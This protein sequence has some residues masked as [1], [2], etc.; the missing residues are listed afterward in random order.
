MQIRVVN[1]LCPNV[2]LSMIVA[3][4]IALLFSYLSMIILMFSSVILIYGY[5]AKHYFITKFIIFSYN[6]LSFH[7]LNDVF[8]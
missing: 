4:E 1:T 3:T 2:F 8:F 6:I 7:I 5:S